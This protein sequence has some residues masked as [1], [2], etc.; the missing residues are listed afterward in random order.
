M[1]RVL[2][3]RSYCVSV[4]K[5]VEKDGE[6]LDF[7][8]LR[9]VSKVPD[10]PIKEDFSTINQAV[11]KINTKTVLLLER[12]ALVNLDGEEALRTLKNSIE[13]AKKIERIDIL[14]KKPLY[15]VLEDQSLHLRSDIVNDGN[16]QGD[17]LKNAKVVEDDYFISPPGNIPLIQGKEN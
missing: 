3:F 2:N 8:S 4:V 12:L 6:K 15:T 5:I 11:T 16:C 9:H 17:I 14:K 10:G 7:M 1:K 13:F